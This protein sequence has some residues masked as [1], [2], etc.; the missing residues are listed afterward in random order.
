MGGVTGVAA[1]LTLGQHWAGYALAVVASVTVCWLL[2]V[3]S[4][5]RL[6]GVTATIVLL[7]PHEDSAARVM[8]VRVS[9]VGW[10]V[11]VAVAV[12]WL[13]SRTGLTDNGRDRTAAARSDGAKPDARSP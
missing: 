9:E 8:L 5:A 11:V 10:G 3:A 2:N 1:V 4:A 13:V 7:V 12:V 6:A